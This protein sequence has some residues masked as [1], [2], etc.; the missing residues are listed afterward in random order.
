MYVRIAIYSFIIIKRKENL[1]MVEIKN[2]SKYYGRNPAVKGIDFEI[3][4]NEILGFLGPNGAGKSTTMNI[5][6]G[7]LPS[8]GAT[9]TV[10][11]FDIAVGIKKEH[12][13]I[14]AASF[15][16]LTDHHHTVRAD[17]KMAF[18]EKLRDIRIQLLRELFLEI[19]DNDEVVAGSVH[20]PEFHVM[21]LR[22]L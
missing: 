21:F 3:R 20:F 1:F 12:A 8:T 16:R 6:A 9:V 22:F 4:D 11:G 18:A 2:L 19:V 5:I 10:N 7:Y 14:R 13:D 17:G 15:G